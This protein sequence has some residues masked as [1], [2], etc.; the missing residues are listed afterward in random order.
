[1]TA[2]IAAAPAF[3]PV[4][5]RSV[6][7]RPR[8]ATKRA[9]AATKAK[10]PVRTSD[11]L[12]ELFDRAGD[13]PMPIREIVGALG[14]TGFGT[15]LMLFSVPEVIPIPIPGL[16]AIVSLPTGFISAQMVMGADGL[17]LPEWLLK[18]TVPG[19]A[20]KKAIKAILPYLEKVERKTRARWAWTTGPLST[21][22]IGAFVFLL[23]LVMAL[24]VPG[25]NMPPAIAIFI[26]GLGLVERDG[27]L[28]ALGFLLGLIAIAIVGG[29]AIGLFAAAFSVFA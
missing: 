26:L 13:G 24:P 11:V 20:L 15:S 22:I 21:R 2:S 17:R 23:A 28:I 5:K 3:A 4:R 12:R 14:A 8:P 18:R 27:R 10:A 6:T 19:K 29:V 9:P 7:A 25:T 16:A 1:M